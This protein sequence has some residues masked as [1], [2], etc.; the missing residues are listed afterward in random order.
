MSNFLSGFNNEET[1]TGGDRSILSE[2]LHSPQPRLPQIIDVSESGLLLL[3]LRI[4][5]PKGPLDVRVRQP[6]NIASIAEEICRKGGYPSDTM[7]EA[8]DRMDELFAPELLEGGYRKKYYRAISRLDALAR[9]GVG[10]EE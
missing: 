7:K 6:H 10:L 1:T 8:F 9:E 4:N 2:D 5:S 3:S